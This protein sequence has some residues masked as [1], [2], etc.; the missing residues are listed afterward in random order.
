MNDYGVFADNY[1]CTLYMVVSSNYCSTYESYEIC[2]CTVYA[3]VKLCAGSF[4][5]SFAVAHPAYRSHCWI[6]QVH[7]RLNVRGA[8]FRPPVCH[9]NVGVR[10][11]ASR[12]Y[13]GVWYFA[14]KLSLYRYP[15]RSTPTRSQ[16]HIIVWFAHPSADGFTLTPHIWCRQPFF[17]TDQAVLLDLAHPIMLD[18]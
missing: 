15:L 5:I 9:K 3:D 6:L 12:I 16:S 13:R 18:M 14:R 2:G 4:L 11:R 7:W 1:L 10:L 17:F 8:I